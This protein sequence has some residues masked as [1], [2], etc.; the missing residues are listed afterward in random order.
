MSPSWGQVNEE[1]P[2]FVDSRVATRPGC[3]EKAWT[4]LPPR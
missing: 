4:L 1:D 2:R 3:W